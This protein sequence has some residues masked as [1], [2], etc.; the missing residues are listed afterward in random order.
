MA[1]IVKVSS[2]KEIPPNVENRAAESPPEP[3]T[4]RRHNYGT[5]KPILYILTAKS[6]SMVLINRYVQYFYHYNIPQ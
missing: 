6:L 5:I 3:L 2:L 1:F 4:T